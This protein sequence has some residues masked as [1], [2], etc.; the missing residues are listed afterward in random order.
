MR[1]AEYSHYYIHH[2]CADDECR[3]LYIPRNDTNTNENGQHEIHADNG[4]EIYHLSAVSCEGDVVNAG[5][6]Y[7][8]IHFITE[9]LT[10]VGFHVHRSTNNRSSDLRIRISSPLI[11]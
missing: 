1:I 4:A 8:E 10:V 3:E 2:H 6:N 5:H 9:I 11:S 7:S